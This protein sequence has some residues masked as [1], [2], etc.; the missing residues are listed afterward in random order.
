M[1]LSQ[2]F[3]SSGRDI[4]RPLFLRRQIRDNRPGQEAARSRRA[5]VA[6]DG[7]SKAVEAAELGPVSLS[8]EQTYRDRICRRR[9]DEF[10]R[11]KRNMAV[12]FAKRFFMS[13]D[14]CEEV[15]QEAALK[16]ARRGFTYDPARPFQ[17]WFFQILSHCAI[18]RRRTALRAPLVIS[19]QDEVADRIVEDSMVDAEEEAINAVH[20]HKEAVVVNDALGRLD[21][22]DADLLVEIYAYE[23]SCKDLA[24][25]A[26]CSDHDVRAK[27]MQVEEEFRRAY[28]QVCPVP[29]A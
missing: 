25:N 16:A 12:N 7:G 26:G 20:R 4:Q 17:T 13:R 23:M 21:L 24:Q 10:M 28:A 27:Q 3:A 1:A 29:T 9:L 18:D 8:P 22:A 5:P 6:V 14:D 19:L 11:T 15:V 2:Q